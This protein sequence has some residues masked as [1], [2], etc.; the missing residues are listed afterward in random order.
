MIKLTELH[1]SPYSTKGATSCSQKNM[2]FSI[3]E[4]DR[5]IREQ[6]FR[7]ELDDKVFPNHIH[8][9]KKCDF[10]FLYRS[11][12]NT[13]M[14]RVLFMCLIELK[15]KHIDEEAI[16][17]LRSTFE[18]IEIPNET[19]RY[20]F[21]VASKNDMP[22]AKTSRQKYMREFKQ[23]YN[24]IFD[25]KNVHMKKCFNELCKVIT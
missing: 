20:A 18:N 10:L 7:V 19:I 2:T 13:N 6:L 22:S 24:A 9:L 15:G 14:E 5:Q 8:G 11:K 4:T 3:E 17:Q 21:V 25:M 16:P 12:D 1:Q 23:K